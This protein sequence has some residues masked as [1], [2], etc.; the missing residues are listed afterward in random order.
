[1]L[2]DFLIWARVRVVEIQ[3]AGFD[4]ALT[5]GVATS[6]SSARIDV[7]DERCLG[8]ITVWDAGSFN[9]EIIDGESGSAIFSR[10]ADFSTPCNFDQL[11]VDFFSEFGIAL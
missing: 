7:E 3:R 8:R 1:M 4:A 5:I 11:F 9:M 6:N 2:S 10:H